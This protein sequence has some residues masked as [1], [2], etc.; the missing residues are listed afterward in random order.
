MAELQLSSAQAAEDETNRRLA[1][2]TDENE[3]MAE[4]INRV[5]EALRLE[6]KRREEIEALVASEWLTLPSKSTRS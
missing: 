5:S 1:E 4:E 6:T 3:Q 2:L